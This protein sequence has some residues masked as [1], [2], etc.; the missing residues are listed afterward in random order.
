MSQS[1]SDDPTGQAKSVAGAQLNAGRCSVIKGGLTLSIMAFWR[2]SDDPEAVIV[3]ETRERHWFWQY[4]SWLCGADLHCRL[5]AA[6]SGR[7]F[8]S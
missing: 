8:S 6:F 3:R 7:P 2:N 4:R 1:A 5:W